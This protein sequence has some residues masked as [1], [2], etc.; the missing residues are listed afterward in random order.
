M[1]QLATIK[2]VS[3]ISPIPDRDRISLATIDG[4]S[5]IVKKDEF[6]VGDLCVYC[7]ID[8]V[9]PEKPEFE[10]LR[11]KNFR[12]KTIKMAGVIS[13]GICFPLSF[14]PD[15]TYKEGQDVTSVLGVTQYEPTMDVERNQRNKKAVPAKYPP[16]LMRFKWFRQLVYKKDH[17]EGMGFPKFISKTDETRIQNIP[18]V[19]QNKTP[20]I[21]TEKIDGQSGTFCLVKKRGFLKNKLEYIVCSRNVRLFNQDSSSYW[22]VSQRY[23]IKNVLEKMIG[24]YEWIAIQGECVAPN[25]QGNKYKVEEADLYVFN[26]ITP[27]GRMGS[28][29]A[30]TF[31]TEHGLKFVPILDTEYVM[32]DTVREVLQYANGKSKIGDTLR[33]GIVFRSHDGKQSFKAVDPLFLLKYDE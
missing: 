18:F 1:R 25:V 21:A 23:D 31:V 12:I 5:V 24:E 7:E 2:K 27:S 11:S 26:V 6:A 28:L 8:S 30:A 4:W 10:F 19:L 20:F 3:S 14:L 22:T 13:Q 9:L 17:R 15:S 16:F 33:E 32:P 29:E